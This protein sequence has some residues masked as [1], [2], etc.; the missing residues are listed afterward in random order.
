MDTMLHNKKSTTA[1][2]KISSFVIFVTLFL[3]SA[4]NYTAVARDEDANSWMRFGNQSYS[5]LFKPTYDHDFIREW[6]KNPPRGYPTISRNNIKP[7]IQAIKRYKKIVKK[8]GWKPIPA[9]AKYTV[10]EVGTT[11]KSVEILQKRLLMSGDLKTES[12]YPTYF[13]YNLDKAVKRFQETNGL[14]PT[15]IVD[16]RTRLALNVPAR[17]RLKQLQLNLNRLRQYAKPGNLRYVVVNI[18]AAHVEAIAN[19]RVVSRHTG[20]VGKIDRKTPILSSYIHELNFNP[21]WKLPP[22]VIKK[23]LIPKGRLM[24]KVKQNVLVRYGIDAYYKGLKIDPSDIDWNSKQPYKL[25]YR[26]KPGPNNPL[27][28]VKIN[29]HNSYSVYLHDSPS[30]RLFGRNIRAASSGCVRVGDIK[31]L[32][33]W[34]LEKNKNWAKSAVDRFEKSGEVRTIRL[35]R[36]IPLH[37]VYVTAWATKNGVVHFRRDLYSRDGVGRVVANY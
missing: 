2:S 28:F 33:A 30:E 21:A 5:N 19:D 24:Q 36:N 11:H 29:F 20:V 9:F 14:T 23:D 18:P 37:I 8:G 10:L 6:E 1:L 3:L 25:S 13:D 12:N 16:R 17:I 32:V 4:T 7:T 22:T 26:Q 15:G 31:L 27:G 35:K 34:L